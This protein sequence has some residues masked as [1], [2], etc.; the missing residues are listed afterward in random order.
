MEQRGYEMIKAGSKDKILDA[1]KRLF[2]EV[3][4]AETTYK[5]I[6]RDAGVADGLI[7]HH[8]GSKENLFMEVEKKILLELLEKL[9]E[10][11]YYASDGLSAVINF[12][13]CMLKFSAEK[14]NGYITLLRCSPFI[15]PQTTTNTDAVIQACD[16]VVRKMRE[17]IKRGMDDG[18]IRRDDPETMANIIFAMIIG[19]TRSYLLNRENLL[20]LNCDENFYPEVIRFLE[21]NLTAG[22]KG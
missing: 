20:S 11:I 12:C 4:Y 3:G 19:A 18:T 6:A 13:K 9:D 5:K 14:N 10:S 22:S 1:A 7:A 8:F 2:G 16:G 17:C 21:E 15:P